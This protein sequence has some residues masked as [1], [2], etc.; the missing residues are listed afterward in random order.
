MVLKSYIAIFSTIKYQIVEKLQGPHGG[1]VIWLT[2]PLKDYH[3]FKIAQLEFLFIY[4]FLNR[5]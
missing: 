4:L 1:Q 3:L 5:N 2:I